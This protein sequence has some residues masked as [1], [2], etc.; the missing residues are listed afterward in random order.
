VEIGGILAVMHRVKNRS[1]SWPDWGKKK[2]KRERKEKK[3][4]SFFF[5]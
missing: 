3:I 4:K 5:F 2:K 1:K